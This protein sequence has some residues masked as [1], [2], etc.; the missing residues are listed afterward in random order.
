MPDKELLLA[1]S[2][3]IRRTGCIE[4]EIGHSDDEGREWYA[5]AKYQ[6]TR[7]IHESTGPDLAALGLAMQLLEG[8][9]CK[10]GRRATLVGASD[11]KHC[12]WSRTGERFNSG[13]DA[14]PMTIDKPGDIAAAD[15]EWRKRAGNS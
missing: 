11:T 2:D 14:P 5:V 13:C 10:C 8:G 6:G 15:R 4:L 7:V 9:R 3:L 1:A 12:L